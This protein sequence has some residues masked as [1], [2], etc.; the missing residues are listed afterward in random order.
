MTQVELMFETILAQADTDRRRKPP[1]WINAEPW[2]TRRHNGR[3]R[4][5]ESAA[6]VAL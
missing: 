4:F 1:L 5:L 2:I 6:T 3:S